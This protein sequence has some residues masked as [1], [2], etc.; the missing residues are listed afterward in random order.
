MIFVS[1]EHGRGISE[2]LDEI[3][4]LLP[5]SVARG[6]IKHETSSIEHPLAIAIVGRPNVGKSS[7]INSIVR[8]ERAI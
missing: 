4:R 8:G 1:A 7:L 6:D 3:E 5:S 2:L